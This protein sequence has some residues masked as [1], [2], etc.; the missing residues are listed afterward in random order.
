MCMDSENN[1]NSFFSLTKKE[2]GKVVGE[3][4]KRKGKCIREWCKDYF[5]M[6][7]W[8][9]KADYVCEILLGMG[10]KEAETIE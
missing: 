10:K 8:H 7:G 3:V 1:N 9:K 5:V 6:R 4:K 2:K